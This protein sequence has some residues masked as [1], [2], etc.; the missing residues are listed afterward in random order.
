MVDENGPESIELS[1]K[2]VFVIVHEDTIVNDEFL[3]RHNLKSPVSTQ[4]ERQDSISMLGFWKDQ[5]KGRV[6]ELEEVKD[7]NPWTHDGFPDSSSFEGIIYLGGAWRDLCVF[8][9]KCQLIMHGFR[10]DQIRIV[11]NATILNNA[12]PVEAP[13]GVNMEID[14]DERLKIL[15]IIDS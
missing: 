6:F 15:E 2:D 13:G 10:S 4:K 5:Y 8:V 12:D 3:F 7:I 11:H 9:V 1:D 14:V